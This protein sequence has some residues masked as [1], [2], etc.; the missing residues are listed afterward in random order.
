MTVSD[1]LPAGEGQPTVST[2]QGTDSVSNGTVTVN[3]GTL[4]A[5]GTATVTIV[6]QA[7]A[8]GGTTLTNIATVT[9]DADDT[10][11][12]TAISYVLAP[13]SKSHFLRPR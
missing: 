7:T 4:D 12:S 8:P 13:P 3:L 10:A 11:Q 2:S 6:V 5:G 9:D 1:P